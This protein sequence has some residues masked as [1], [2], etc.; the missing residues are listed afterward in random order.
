MS[1]SCRPSWPTGVT[2]LDLTIYADVGGYNSGGSSFRLGKYV[3][4]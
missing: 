3:F 2:L 1:R 4:V